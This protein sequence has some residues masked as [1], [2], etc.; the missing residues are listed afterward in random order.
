MTK[1]LE[2][3]FQEQKRSKL[4]IYAYSIQ[5]EAH[6]GQLKIGQTTQEVKVRVAQQLKTAGIKN[7]KIE[8][9]DTAE[10]DD[11][12]LMSDHDVRAR[13][14]QKGFK[15]VQLEWMECTLADVE[16]A[17][18][19]LRQGKAIEGTHH[20]SFAMRP[21]QLQ[22]VV[23]THD[24]Y[25]SITKENMHAVPRFLWNAKMRFG[26]TFASYQLAKRMGAKKVLILTF[27]PAV[28]DSWRS[29]LESHAD[30]EGWQYLSKANQGDPTKA[31]K[32]R[33]LVYFG[34]FQD[35]LGKDVNGNIKSKNEWLH[36]TK[37]DL[38]IFDEYH[39]GAWRDNAKE[40]FEGE[41]EEEAKKEAALEYNKGLANLNEELD[42][43]NEI[44][45]DFL[46]I[47]TRAYLYLSGT[48]FKALQSGEFIEE[49]IF[50]WTYSDEQ[51]AKEQWAEKYPEKRNPYGA[52]PQMRLLTYQMPDELVAIAKQGEF[53]EFDNF[54]VSERV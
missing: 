12:S 27:K 51:R 38:V 54:M 40:L 9:E 13:L 14:A 16:T 6:A 48:P 37:W 8:L 53:D 24:Y 30:F 19:E 52:L 3:I 41:D 50:N 49:Q 29:D 43:L 17:I 28:E 44:E 32:K 4:R 20:E 47:S 7:Y 1:P 33:P 46:P 10:K 34:S 21:E 35:L 45:P 11:G 39:F 18:L 42:E 23:K 31:D 36:K 26:K 25:A 2:Q 15:K 22:A 5:D